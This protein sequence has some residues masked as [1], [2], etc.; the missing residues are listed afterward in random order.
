VNQYEEAHIFGV[1]DRSL[2]AD[3]V[4][5]VSPFFLIDVCTDID[6]GGADISLER[7]QAS[8]A[9]VPVT[10]RPLPLPS[11]SISLCQTILRAIDS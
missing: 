9:F 5:Q 6:T 4:S 10:V 8:A 1:P 11:P 2:M 7:R 3:A